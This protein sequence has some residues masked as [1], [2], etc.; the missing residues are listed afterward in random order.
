MK[1][2]LSTLLASSMALALLATPIQAYTGSGFTLTDSWRYYSGYTYSKKVENVEL[3][4][5]LSLSNELVQQFLFTSN[6]VL[7]TFVAYKNANNWN[8]S[9]KSCSNLRTLTFADGFNLNN[10]DISNCPNLEALILP[11]NSV[12]DATDKTWFSGAKTWV[13]NAPNLVVYGVPGTAAEE[14]ANDYEI[15]FENIKNYGVNVAPEVETTDKT[16]LPSTA[17]V[18]VNG[19]E[20]PFGAYEIDGF[21]YFKLTDMSYALNGT[22]KEFL[23]SWDM[24]KS[25]I[26]MV[27][28]SPHNTLGTEMQGNTGK[29]EVA[30]LLTTPVFKDGEEIDVLVYTIEGNSYFQLDTLKGELDL[31]VG[32]DGESGTITIDTTALSE[33]IE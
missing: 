31:N 13:S 8:F 6:S 15:P 17:K 16:A 12:Y 5:N 7:E 3:N 2:I 19:E 14:C 11:G 4:P 29:N 20:L 9:V 23:V 27:T 33:E 22:E 26:N 18:M 1:K 32:W 21:N 30:E 25:A 24:E 10:L 28:G